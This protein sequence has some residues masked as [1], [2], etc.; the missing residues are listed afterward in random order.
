MIDD[1]LYRCATKAQFFNLHLRKALDIFVNTT[2]LIS[3]PAKDT[4]SVC[5]ALNN[6]DASRTKWN[7]AASASYDALRER[8]A[9]LPLATKSNKQVHRY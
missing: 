8:F 1:S 5:T 9:T 3:L 2:G 6:S 7:S 4:F